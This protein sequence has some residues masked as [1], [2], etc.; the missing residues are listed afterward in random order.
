[1]SSQLHLRCC[2]KMFFPRV[3]T[4]SVFNSTNYAFLCTSAREALLGYFGVVLRNNFICYS[5]VKMLSHV[6]LVE[7][8]F[9]STTTYWSVSFHLECNQLLVLWNF[10]WA[11]CGVF[12]VIDWLNIILFLENSKMFFR[13]LFFEIIFLEDQCFNPLPLQLYFCQQY[14]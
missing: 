4:T 14:L 8:V 3:W 9:F 12:F 11:P 2:V 13:A 10:C 1:M 5:K 7:I 6:F